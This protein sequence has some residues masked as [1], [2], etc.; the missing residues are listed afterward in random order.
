MEPKATAVAFVKPEPLI[1]TMFPPETGPEEGL[2]LVIV[3]AGIVNMTALM[4]NEVLY[5][6]PTWKGK[7]DQRS[8][9]KPEQMDLKSV[10]VWV[11]SSSKQALTVKVAWLSGLRRI[12]RFNAPHSPVLKVNNFMATGL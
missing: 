2:I 3:G 8:R 10:Q 7:E 4:W 11:K 12:D 1:D 6:F 5:C 9:F